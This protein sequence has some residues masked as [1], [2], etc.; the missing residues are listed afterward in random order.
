MY[1]NPCEV[2]QG[3]LKPLGAS[4]GPQIIFSHFPKIGLFWAKTSPFGAP[5]GT[6][7]AL[8]WSNMAYNHVLYPCEVFQGHLEP[9]GASTAVLVNSSQWGYLQGPKISILLSWK[10]SGGG[11][12]PDLY[13]IFSGSMSIIWPIFT[14]IED[15]VFSKS[16]LLCT[17]IFGLFCPFSAHFKLF[18]DIWGLQTSK[19]Y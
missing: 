2:F 12:S 9:L 4:P 7:K 17:T 8:G 10:I 13:H 16:A 18:L 11:P 1:Y 19:T 5:I 3:H 6:Q 15:D 14:Q